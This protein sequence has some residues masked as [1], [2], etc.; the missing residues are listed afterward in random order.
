MYTLSIIFD[1]LHIIFIL[2]PIGIY[3][4]PK[5][6]FWI[7]RIIILLLLLTPL[8]WHIFKNSCLLTSFSK[9]LGGLANNKYNSPF[10]EK[11]LGWLM[12]PILD[13][14]KMER[15]KINVSKAVNIQWVINY[16]IIYYYIFHY[17]NCSIKK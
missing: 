6:Y 3:F 11:Y 7:T 5:K 12:F 1:I 4:I 15:N 9:K 8:H 16:I 10:T 13:F 2:M 14:F 17:L